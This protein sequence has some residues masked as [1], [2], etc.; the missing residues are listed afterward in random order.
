[1]PF[2]DSFERPISY[3]R[4]SV[5]DWCSNSLLQYLSQP[6]LSLRTTC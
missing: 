4:I 3:L 5:A 2:L 6:P 1:M